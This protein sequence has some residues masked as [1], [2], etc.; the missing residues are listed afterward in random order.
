VPSLR[1]RSSSS[2]ED[3]VDF[4][5]AG[6]YDSYTHKFR[7]EGAL[8]ETVKQ[9]WGSLF[10][11]RAVAER[12]AAG[13]NHLAVYMGVL[14]HPNYGTEQANGVAVTANA[15]GPRPFP[16]ETTDVYFNA[17]YG[18]VSVVN[19]PLDD[20]QTAPTPDIFVRSVLY[21]I[22]VFDS[23]VVAAADGERHGAERGRV[24]GA[25][26]GDDLNS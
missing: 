13:L 6:L 15:L 17:Q 11:R 14:V 22:S 24:A 2:A 19:P 25:R 7:S 9:V 1:C 4:S 12:D 3:L 8:S 5:G 21:G 10:T 16:Y 26:A 20:N 18:E 23:V